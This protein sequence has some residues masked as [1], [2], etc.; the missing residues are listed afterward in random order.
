M[1]MNERIKY[2]YDE[3]RKAGMTYQGTIGLLG[4][5]QGETSDFDPMSLET[6]YRNRFGLTDAEYVRRA[7]AG[8][9][10]YNNYTFV[11]DSAGFGIAQWTW[12][13]RKQNLLDFAKSMGKS[14]G[15]L[16]LQVAFMIKEMQLKY[17]KTWK[18]LTTTNDYKEAVKICVNEYEKPA[19][20]STA[21]QTRCNYAKAFLT[22]IKDEDTK[23]EQEQEKVETAT[24]TTSTNVNADKAIAALIA[25]AR[26]ELGYLEKRS[27]SQ[28]YD[29]TANAGSNNY[30]KYADFIDKN[31]P[32]FY[33]GQ[34]NGFA[35]CD[36]FVDS[37]YIKTFGYDMALKLLCAPEKSSGAGC[38]YSA[39]YYKA[40]GQ[41]I[42]RGQ[43][44]PKV[45]DQIFF[46]SSGSETHTGIV[47]AVNDTTVFT[48]EGNTSPSSGVIANGGG[49]YE[50]QYAINYYYISGYGRPD[51]SLV[52][53]INNPV[54]EETATPSIVPSTNQPTTTTTTTTTT[55]KEE[56]REVEIILSVL[57]QGDKGVQVKALQCLLISNGFSCGGYGADG[58]F[59]N[60][61]LAA[62]KNYQW[63]NGL[64]VD[65]ICGKNTWTKLLK[66]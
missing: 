11:K 45:G 28:L 64:D 34:K 47:A 26:A 61:T 25:A 42:K 16:G 24:P 21:I 1:T 41:F 55:K 32:N 37:L 62:L 39:N 40:K 14:V 35:W 3:C 52:K 10:V 57:K 31:Y 22:Q 13:E 46:G 15:D 2:I 17:A 5:L 63:K 50:K 54:I 12:W 4:N 19:N 29:N 20:A 59:G 44:Q 23:I 30:N 27:N 33:N 58:D 36:V 49:V 38:I 60:G 65:G 56:V 43:G 51:Y 48:I 18:I 8:E 9:K 6:M 53:A 7:D 66:G